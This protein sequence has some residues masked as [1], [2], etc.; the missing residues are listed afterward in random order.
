MKFYQ[1]HNQ[2]VIP[3]H[4]K[5]TEIEGLTPIKSLTELADPT[6]TSISIVTPP[7][8]RCIESRT[9]THCLYK[10]TLSVLEQAKELNVPAVWIQPGAE[11]ENVIKYVEENGMKDKVVYGGACVLVLG[12]GA[13]KRLGK[14]HL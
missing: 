6:T 9:S 11:D 4:P 14:S 12:D 13:L 7:K 2:N 8:V 3:V 10:V 1:T 5:E